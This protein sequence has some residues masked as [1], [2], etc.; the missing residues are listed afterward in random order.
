[1]LLLFLSFFFFFYLDGLGLFPF[2]INYEI[3]NLT[4][5]WAS[6]DSSVGIATGYGLDDRGVGARVPIGSRIFSSPR[7]KRPVLGPNQPPIQWV[8]G[9]ISPGVKRPWREDDYSPPISAEVKNTRIYT[10]TPPYVFMA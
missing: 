1:L 8:P 9:A 3:T 5:S 4:D 7:R 2:R 10:S 6:R